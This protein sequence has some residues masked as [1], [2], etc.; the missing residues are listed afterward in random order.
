MFVP[1]RLTDYDVGRQG[2]TNEY[3]DIVL[4]DH[5]DGTLGVPLGI[6]LQQDWDTVATRLLV[7][8]DCPGLPENIAA[9]I[10]LRI[11]VSI[12]RSLGVEDD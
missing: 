8:C 10:S 3:S 6:V 2:G 4:F 11:E 7:D 1:L 5:V 9:K 12:C